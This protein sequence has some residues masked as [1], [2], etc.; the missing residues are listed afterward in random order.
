LSTVIISVNPKAGRTSPRQRAEALQNLLQEK[1]FDV[2]LLTDLNEVAQKATELQR[3]GH[4]Q[5]LVGCGGDGTAATLVNLTPA[6]TPIT[7]L[8]AGTANL[9]AKEFRLPKNLKKLADLI[10][11]GNSITLDAGRAVFIKNGERTE[12]LFLVMAGCG[13]DADVVN[14]VH[15]FREE[16]LQSGSKHGAHI[17]YFSYI[18]PIL[19][20]LF[21]YRF[22]PMSVESFNTETNDWQLVSDAAKWAFFF[23]LNRYG[24]GLPLAPS[25][26]GND[27]LLDHTLFYGGS[28]FHGLYYTA[29]AQ[30]KLHGLL[31]GTKL[32]QSQRYRISCNTP[33]PF[34]LDGDPCGELPMELEIIPQRVRLLV[35]KN[36]SL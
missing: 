23:N 15:R 35:P 20:T 17:S 21:G 10:A 9:L 26:R 24:W 27:G 4:L 34:Q 33:L 12:R 3:G 19:K 2:E 7:L 36:V 30:F 11:E 25:A 29:F 13:F 1:G 8:A 18:K 22:A 28:V 5:A 16:R 32:G 14:G 31:K 6:G